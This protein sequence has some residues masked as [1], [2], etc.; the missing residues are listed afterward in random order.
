MQTFEVGV[1]ANT[2]VL[3]Q[4]SPPST[5]ATLILIIIIITSIYTHKNI[6]QIYN[7]P[8]KVIALT[9]MLNVEINK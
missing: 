9:K 8:K 1:I 4:A 6:S 3:V 7:I 5:R 2:V